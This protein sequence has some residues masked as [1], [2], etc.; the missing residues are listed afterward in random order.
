[1][2]DGAHRIRRLRWRLALRSREEAAAFRARLG[3]SVNSAIGPALE[4]AFDSLAAGDHVIHLARLEAAV[5][6]ESTDDLESATVDAIRT[7]LTARLA[8]AS[9][10]GQ[11][12]SSGPVRRSTVRLSRLESILQYLETG[13]LPWYAQPETADL[14]HV[15]ELEE[16]AV[17]DLT[18][19]LQHLP[20]TP[21]EA[22]VFLFRLL[23]LLPDSG[24]LS[25]VYAVA[26][27][28]HRPEEPALFDAIERIAVAPERSSGR[29]ARL[30]LAAA[31]IAGWFAPVER[32]NPQ[33]APIK[34]AV[35]S[36]ALR[37]FDRLALPTR[38]A[39][40]IDSPRQPSDLWRE[41]ARPHHDD[42]SPDGAQLRVPAF[43][44][45][46]VVLTPFLPR[47]FAARNVAHPGEQTLTPE[48]LRRAAALLHFAATGENEGHEYELEFIKALLGVPADRAI[49]FASGILSRGDRDEVETVL[50]D[51][52]EQWYM[53]K[54]S[55][56]DGLRHAFLQRRGLLIDAGDSWRL[57]VESAAVDVLLDHLPW[58]LTTVALPWLPKPI[59]IDWPRF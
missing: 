14:A 8:E 33:P 1:M 12:A 56:T 27:Q 41:T 28:R 37:L 6:V 21:G 5:R 17:S 39:K 46:L 18:A 50:G 53:L 59:A 10:D 55:S 34:T 40:P 49:L 58:S 15:R 36:D 29:H 4:R 16:T 2:S 7:A 38:L 42:R 32:P 19:V 52:V 54:H 45:G 47:L 23:S 22:A 24:W 35:S 26:R 48:A 3:R 11:P 44:A 9:D 51:V 13:T 43:Y 25:V 20:T 57:R 31:I 30:E